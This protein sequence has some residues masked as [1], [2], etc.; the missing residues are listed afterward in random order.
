MQPC[1]PCDSFC[2]A[3]WLA[4][5]W[6]HCWLSV[7][8]CWLQVVP[9]AVWAC[10][11]P[12]GGLAICPPKPGAVQNPPLANARNLVTKSS[13][14]LENPDKYSKR[15]RAGIH[16]SAGSA[17]TSWKSISSKAGAWV[18]MLELLNPNAA[19]ATMAEEH[20]LPESGNWEKATSIARS[21]VYNGGGPAWHQ[22]LQGCPTI[23]GRWG[24]QLHK[25]PQRVIK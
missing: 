23:Q 16:T 18:E 10:I 4:C 25:Q 7:W 9:G 12:F 1:A 19:K 17:G 13:A 6:W 14:W 8:V 24:S 2:K 21:N 3:G 22:V 5:V 20:K 15:G 11:C